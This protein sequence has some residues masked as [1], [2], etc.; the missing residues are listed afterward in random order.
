MSKRQTRSDT[1]AAKRAIEYDDWQYKMMFILKLVVLNGYDIAK[2][3]V[4][5][6]RETWS[7]PAGLSDE[8]SKLVRDDNVFWQNIINEKKKSCFDEG[9][10]RLHWA[11][12]AGV[13][14][15]NMTDRVIQLVKWGANIEECCSEGTPLMMAAYYEQLETLRALLKLGA[16][17][18]SGY[19]FGIGRTVLLLSC[20]YNSIAIVKELL[21]AG[22][23]V[24][25]TDFNG[26]FP[27]FEAAK[28]GH[29]TVYSM[30]LEAGADKNRMHLLYNMRTVDMAAT[31][32]F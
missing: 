14:E 21:A 13:R 5:L 19:N 6:C 18:N 8:D 17:V 2:S 10:T 1:R 15:D 12:R 26:D 16:D 30:L 11:V 4:G 28:K 29:K 7:M 27:L 32:G 24:E 25:K 31:K 22:A 20:Q 9:Q 3:C 23:D